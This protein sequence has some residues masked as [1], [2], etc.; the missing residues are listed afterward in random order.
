MTHPSSVSRLASDFD[1]FLF[2]PVGE[3]KNGMPLSVLSTLARL[4][5]DPWQEA[6]RLAGA[7]VKISTEGLAS[8][9]MALPGRTSTLL[10][11]GT[12]AARLI[13]L[14]PRRV[15]ANVALGRSPRGVGAMAN[16]QAI[17]FVIF[18]VLTLGVQWAIM[19]HQ[20]PA[21][22]DSPAAAGSSTVLPPT[23]PPGA[24]Q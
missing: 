10:D 20:A 4:N 1:D 18:M 6:A 15:V 21:K 7:P 5:L 12:I 11:A 14:L 19:S 8:L 24:G 23:A 3:E 9:I 22:T 16:P 2:A 13:A 17:L